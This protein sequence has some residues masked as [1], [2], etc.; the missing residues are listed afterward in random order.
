MKEIALAALVFLVMGSAVGQEMEEAGMENLVRYLDS[1]VEPTID[2]FRNNPTSVRHAF[3]ACVVVFHAV[4]YLAFPRKSP[5]LR[6]KLGNKSP[7]FKLVD[8]VAHAF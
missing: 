7:D 3:L 6:Q 5:G 8:E 1:I 4:D 2:D